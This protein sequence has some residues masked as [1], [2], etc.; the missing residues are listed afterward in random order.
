MLAILKK[1]PHETKKKL[2]KKGYF[3]QE[4]YILKVLPVPPNCL[5]IP[6]VSDG[7]SVLSMVSHIHALANSLTSGSGLFIML[8]ATL[9]L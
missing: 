5:S 3:P 7:V 6:D 1:L 8:T 2:V 4:G 9:M